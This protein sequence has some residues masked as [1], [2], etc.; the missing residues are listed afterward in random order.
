MS[1]GKRTI[2]K[3]LPKIT[4]YSDETILIKDIR[5]SYPHLDKP[6]SM[7]D[8]NEKKFSI[9]GLIPKTQE[10]NDST[11]MLNDHIDNMLAEM[12][13]QPLPQS[14]KCL[15]D[16]DQTGKLE[17][18]GH[19]TISASEREQPKLRGRN[20]DPRTGSLEIIPPEEAARVF[21]GGCWVS[22]LISLW[23]QEHQVGGRRVNAN[24]RAVQ[25]MR[26]DTSFGRGR[27][28]DDVIDDTFEPV[29]DDEGGFAQQYDL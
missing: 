18:A 15:R 7:A 16:G 28:S 17:M 13:K 12:K 8:G 23:Y 2:I 6:W 5:A 22:I 19:W 25:F 9:T 11:R 21:Y 1:D 29:P 10:Y 27:I 26:N 20:I 3:Q 24:L 14:R 4:F